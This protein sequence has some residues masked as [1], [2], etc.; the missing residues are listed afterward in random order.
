MFSGRWRTVRRKSSSV[1]GWQST[2]PGCTRSRQNF[3][4]SSY[5]YDSRQNGQ[6]RPTPNLD[7][8]SDYA[9]WLLHLSVWRRIWAA[10]M[11]QQLRHTCFYEPNMCDTWWG[12]FY[13]HMH[14]ILTFIT[15][16]SDHI[17]I[18]RHVKG[19][20]WVILKNATHCAI[21]LAPCLA[22]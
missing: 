11:C 3:A 6:L 8:D 14:F 21:C 15:I 18:H 12:R 5:D 1:D 19:Y 16:I 4:E 2:T 7:L 10:C 20:S 22:P 17:R 9:P 13:N